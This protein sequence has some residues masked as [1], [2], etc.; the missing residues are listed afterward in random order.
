MAHEFQ[1]VFRIVATMLDPSA[2]EYL[3]PL[4]VIAAVRD[5]Y[6]VLHPVAK[7]LR[8]FIAQRGF[9]SLVR[10]QAQSPFALEWDVS[11]N[12]IPLPGVALEWVSQHGGSV[13]HRKRNGSIATSGVDH[14]NLATPTRY[15]LKK[16][17]K[18]ALLVFCKNN[19][20]DRYRQN[21]STLGPNCGFRF[22]R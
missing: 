1:E 7:E 22:L 15:T 9:Q 6:M 16:G 2:A 19:D 17:P 4:D 3:P 11:E 5:W 13:F 10:I 14:K 21:T 20:A 18:V 12:P 8:D